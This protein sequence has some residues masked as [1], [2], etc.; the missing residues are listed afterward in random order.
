MIVEKTLTPEMKVVD[1]M[2]YVT[3]AEKGSSLEIITIVGN[4][5][6]KLEAKS[7]TFTYDLNGLA[8]GI[9][10]FKMGEIVRKFVV[11]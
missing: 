6:Q 8:K 10:I 7:S 2:L 9:Y 1:N 4:R 3:N 11:K 5:I